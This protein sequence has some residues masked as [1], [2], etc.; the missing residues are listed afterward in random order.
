MSIPL[1]SL[2]SAVPCI[3]LGSIYLVPSTVRSLL[4]KHSLSTLHQHHPH[5]RHVYPSLIAATL[6]TLAISTL[7]FG[8][9]PSLADALVA[10]L[11][12][13]GIVKGRPR[14]GPTHTSVA[15]LMRTYLK[16]IMRNDDSRKIFYFLMVNLAYMVV[17]M[18][19]GFWTNSLGLVSDGES[20]CMEY[21]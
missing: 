3:A 1:T 8:R 9:L 17:Q 18:M 16:I 6:P 19:W 10:G 2:L 21:I 13:V 11:L 20:H 12:Y 4:S 14:E 5:P 15:R 7:I